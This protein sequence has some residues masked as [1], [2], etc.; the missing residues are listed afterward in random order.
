MSLSELKFP[1]NSL[2]LKKFFNDKT[3]CMI[4]SFSYDYHFVDHTFCL[5]TY[6]LLSPLF[7]L[8]QG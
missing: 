5:I 8:S 6:T 1:K 2:F 4:N 3:K 7:L